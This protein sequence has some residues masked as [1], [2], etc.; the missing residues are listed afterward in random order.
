[1]TDK[2]PICNNTI[3]TIP[4]MPVV[5]DCVNSATEITKALEYVKYPKLLEDQ[6]WTKAVP[7]KY[8]STYTKPSEGIGSIYT[9]TS[10]QYRVNTLT[11]K[12][13]H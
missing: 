2:R 11:K 12:K 7:Y 9:P 10:A 3:P 8:W 1:M 13:S 4:W 6:S 5:E